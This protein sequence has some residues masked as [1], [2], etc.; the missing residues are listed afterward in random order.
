L[1]ESGFV[2]CCFNRNWKFTRSVFDVWMRLLTNIPDSV[3]W[4]GESSAGVRNNLLK[5]ALARGISWQRIIF[6]NRVVN[7][8][9]Y[10]GWQ[11]HSDLFLDT[12]PYNAHST[13]SDALWAGL[14]VVTCKGKSFSGRV[15]ASLLHALAMPEL[16]T[17][18][19]VDYERVALT[20]AKNPDRLRNVR[21]KLAK[22]RLNSQ[23][24]DTDRFT[25]H[26]EAAFIRMLE[27]A[28][29]GETPS[30]FAITA[31]ES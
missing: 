3:L 19:L 13:A 7:R 24:F 11:S 2:F 28:R 15:A 14:P 30:S 27:I 1:P 10:L 31:E 8:S 9:E 26:I 12:V 29:A 4:L 20:L 5:E 16:I 25:R 18:S 6:N 23:L 22:N 17:D 21:Q